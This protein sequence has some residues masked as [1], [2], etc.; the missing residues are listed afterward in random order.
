MRRTVL[1]V[2]VL[3]C[4]LAAAQV[5]TAWVRRYDGPAH[6]NDEARAL[7]V[8]GAGNVYVTGESYVGSERSE[9]VTIKYNANGDTEWVQRYGPASDRFE[10]PAALALDDSGNVYVTG[11]ARE[12]SETYYVTIKYSPNGDTQWVRRYNLSGSEN[13]AYALAVDGA[14]SAYVTGTDRICATIKYNANGDTQ[15]VRRYGV[16]QDNASGTALALDSA[17]NVY[18]A[19]RIYGGQPSGD[20]YLTIKYNADGDTQWV[21][22]FNGGQYPNYSDGATALAVD[23]FG[24]VYV[25]GSSQDTLTVVDYL[26]IKYNADG[27]TQWVRRYDGPS[28]SGDQARTLAL[29]GAGNVYVTGRSGDDCTTIKYG[30]SGDTLWLRRRSACLGNALVVD[31]VGSVYV[32]GANGDTLT[33]GDYSTV[34]YNPNGD[35]QWVVAYNGPANSW[36]QAYA[37]AVDGSGN[38]Y[39]TG[40]SAN[41]ANYDFATVKYVQAGAVA[42]EATGARPQQAPSTTVVRGVLSVSFSTLGPQLSSLLDASGRNV[43]AVHAGRNDVSRLAPGVYFI[44][45]QEPSIMRVIVTR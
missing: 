13:H 14:G 9:C 5:D 15:W 25:T 4:G 12:I 27:D 34:K 26:T 40:G 17:G 36:D 23:D 3:A 10:T 22:C 8:D 2:L 41:A 43:Q 29:D 19:G 44:R 45:G 39:V 16:S 21:R 1:V 37:L 11:T 28:H 18:V 30:A 31:G 38:V 6:G 24:N 42:D 33:L 35:S 20:D 32:T 7:A